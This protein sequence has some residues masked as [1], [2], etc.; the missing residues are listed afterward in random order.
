[1]RRLI[2][3]TVLAAIAVPTTG[4]V[5]AARHVAKEANRSGI[6]QK[7]HDRFPKGSSIAVARTSLAADGYRCLDLPALDKAPAHTSCW[8]KKR[9][10]A[11]ERFLVGGNW[12]WDFYGDGDT[13]TKVHISSARHG[14]KK[15]R[16]AAKARVTELESMQ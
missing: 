3:I 12:R 11:P 5:M 4:C 16:E 9:T 13:L 15:Y 2:A 6:Q 8:P 7:A 10:S 1:M 14:M